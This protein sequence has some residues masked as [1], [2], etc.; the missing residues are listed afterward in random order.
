MKSS[1]WLAALLLA[2]LSFSAVKGGPFTVTIST[3]HVQEMGEDVTCQAVITNNHDEDYYLLKRNTPLE[4]IRSRTYVVRKGM[5]TLVEYDGFFFK[6]APPTEEEYVLVPGKTSVSSNVVLSDAYS[7]DGP[8]VYSVQLDT[9]VL[10]SKSLTAAPLSQPLSS[11][12][13]HFLLANTGKASKLTQA[14]IIRR[15]KKPNA[16]S[17]TAQQV[18]QPTFSG[19]WSAA[20]QATAVDAYNRAIQ[21]VGDSFR[22]LDRDASY[23]EW[24]GVINNRR[25]YTVHRVYWDIPY[26]LVHSNNVVDFVHHGAHCRPGDFAYTCYQCDYIS[27]CDSYFRAPLVGFNSKMGTIIHELTHTV[28][29]TDDHEYGMHDCRV[30]AVNNPDLAVDNADNYEYYSESL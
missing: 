30:L 8:S 20:D 18:N 12:T 19:G 27:F 9:Q 4:K 1:L 10:Y 7:F 24:F 26:Y 3:P 23:R 15:N 11:N 2:V 22:A 25:L 29:N 17:V 5:N 14:E 28:K 13:R 6:R 21:K 16:A